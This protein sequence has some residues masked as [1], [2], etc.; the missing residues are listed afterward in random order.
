MRASLCVFLLVTL[1]TGCEDMDA[2]QPGKVVITNTRL[3]VHITPWEGGQH[4]PTQLDAVVIGRVAEIEPEAVTVA[5]YKGARKDH[6]STYKVASLKIDDRVL[7]AAGLTILRVGFLAKDAPTA[8]TPDMEGCFT[9]SRHNTADFYVLVS[10]PVSKKDAAYAAELDRVKKVALAISDPVAALK[11][12]DLQDR[13]AAALYLSYRYQTPRVSMDR[14][15]IPEEE[16]K[17]ILKLLT[18]LPWNPPGVVVEGPGKPT[19]HRSF[20]WYKFDMGQFVSSGL[21]L[22]HF[23]GQ[24]AHGQREHR[25]VCSPQTPSA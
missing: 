7:G 17:L 14:E 18:E 9:L 23:R 12:E 6:W 21:E 25:S 3:H 22:Y 8:L 11:A 15:P 10:R 13:F 16:N 19:P 1:I 24:V 4:L 20:L 2:R 5:D